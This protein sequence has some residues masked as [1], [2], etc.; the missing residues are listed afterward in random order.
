M[1][2]LH[3][4]NQKTQEPSPDSI[5]LAL[6][7]GIAITL[8]VYGYQFG[9]S[10]HTI[11][12][13]D[14]LHRSDSKILARD[15]FTT[16][17][18]Q[19]HAAFG[20][21]TRGLMKLHA[22]ESGFLAG[23]LALVIAFHLAW[24]RLVII[25]GGT[26]KTYLV[27]VLMYHIS[28]GGTALGMYQFFQ[29]SAFLASNIA[30]V[31]LL[32]AMV[33]W[34]DRHGIAAGICI[35]VAGMFHLNHAVVG[36]L[37]WLSRTGWDAISAASRNRAMTIRRP[38]L[39]L[40]DKQFWIATTAALAPCV[41]NIACAASL[42]LKSSGKMPLSEF[43]DLYVRLRH[44][45]HYDP[46]S[47]PAALWVSFLWPML[48]AL[49]AYVILRRAAPPT[50]RRNIRD[51]ARIF[52]LIS[53]LLVVALLGAGFWCVSESLV[54]M[55]LYRFSIYLQLF[56][57]IGASLLVCDCARLA[58]PSLYVVILGLAALI[59]L[60]PLLMWAGP[61]MGWISVQGMRAFINHKRGGLILFA[62]LSC[63]PAI[64]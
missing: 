16:Q 28:A 14:A 30:N 53:I 18:F 9:R 23:Y 22:L 32:C 61:R 13:L 46:R 25:L 3:I 55:S 63:A 45:H 8:C 64:H 7:I 35:G 48:P 19:Y 33:L 58:R 26:L 11:Y 20:C 29:D 43:V 44:P 27:S 60:T 1:S 38:I 2:S 24:L 42:T 21:I 57:C 52:L 34:I 37:L 36:S 62:V 50:V 39:P 41:I 49:A 56:A 4:D 17:T 10:N 15:W 59:A 54:Q 12:L 5:A 47:W 40:R 51:A 6:A 31:L